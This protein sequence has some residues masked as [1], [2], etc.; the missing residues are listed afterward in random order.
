A[1][2][3]VGSFD[4]NGDGIPDD[5]AAGAFFALGVTCKNIPLAKIVVLS[6]SIRD[7]AE[8]RTCTGG[9]TT[10]A[11]TARTNLRRACGICSGGTFNG[12]ACAIDAQCTG[13]NCAPTGSCPGGSCVEAA[14]SCGDGDAFA[15]RGEIIRLTLALQN[16]TGYNLT[17]INLSITT[18]DP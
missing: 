6:T 8:L 18:A 10:N 5:T 2:D 15:D 16:V 7:R 1:C 17:G 4:E 14:N 9:P 3:P 11:C 12:S 13:G